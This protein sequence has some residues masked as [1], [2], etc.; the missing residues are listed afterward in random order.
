MYVII[1]IKYGASHLDSSLHLK[2]D[3]TEEMC[4]KHILLNISI[5][6]VL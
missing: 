2:L 1:I 3:L 5:I 6:V 4:S